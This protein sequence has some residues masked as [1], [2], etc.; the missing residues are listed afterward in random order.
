MPDLVTVYTC[1]DGTEFPV[2][3]EDPADIEQ[4]WLR[5]TSHWP[6]PVAPVEPEMWRLARPGSARAYAEAEV[7]APPQFRYFLFPQGYLYLRVSPLAPE[8]VAYQAQAAERLVERMGGVLPVWEHHCLPRIVE[9]CR[10]LQAAGEDTPVAALA[11]AM[12]YAFNL[13]HVAGPVVLWSVFEPLREFCVEQFG[14]EGD[15]LA[16]ELTQGYDNATLAVDQ[17][18]W[19]LA[20]LARALPPVRDALRT[21]APEEALAAVRAAAGSGPF[22]AAFERLLERYRR[23]AEGWDLLSPTWGER[24]SSPL[25]LVRRLLV[26][27]APSPAKATRQAAARREAVMQATK[28]RLADRPATL[29]HF[30]ALLEPAAWYVAV[31]EGRALWQLIITGSTRGALLRKG[32]RLCTA[33]ALRDPGDVLFLLPEEIDGPARADLPERLAMRRAG[34][35][36]HARLSPPPFIGTTAT[37]AA[38]MRTPAAAPAGRALLR[39]FGASR[40]VVTARARVITSLND[41]ERLGPGEVLVCVMTT[42]AWTPLFGIAGA[43]V[44][45]S[46]GLLSHPAIAAREYG[47]PAVVGAGTATLRIPDGALI[48]VDGA[49]GTVEVRG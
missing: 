38:T 4:T 28:A 26:E 12:G 6:N 11:D 5:D 43:V 31:R 17:E 41:G 46:G 23:R 9:T 30:R 14:P 22:L 49:A 33:G 15:L 16:Y 44:T 25:A 47:I 1:A 27:D 10:W 8:E 19:E 13:T 37:P 24:P 35:E 21:S 3:W 34:W 42:P 40:G 39:G 18:L 20:Q 29:A 7:L 36:R 2:A 45:D 48:T 32:Q